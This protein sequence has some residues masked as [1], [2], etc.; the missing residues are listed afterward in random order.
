[1][2]SSTKFFELQELLDFLVSKKFQLPPTNAVLIRP[3]PRP[4]YYILHDDIILIN[5]LG[6]GAFGEVWK[7]VWRK[8][9][10]TS[11]DVAVKRMKGNS[12]KSVIKEF[13]KEAK[14]MRK[15]KHPNIV[16]IIGVAPSEEPLMIC[17][18]L[19]SNGCLKNYLKMKKCTLDQLTNFCIDAARGMSYLSSQMIIHRDLAARNLLLGS[20]IEVKIADFGLSEAGKTEVKINKMKLP[21]RWLA[22]ETIDTGWFTTKTDVWSYA[23][24]IWE[25]FSYCANDPFPGLTNNQA[26]DLIRTK[27]PPMQAPND[28]PSII[29]RLMLDCFEKKPENRPTFPQL[30]KKLSPKEDVEQYNKQIR[31]H[32]GNGLSASTCSN[33]QSEKGV[34]VNGSDLKIKASKDGNISSDR[35]VRIIIPAGNMTLPQDSK[36]S[37]TKM[38]TSKPAK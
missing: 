24:T 2:D 9:D 36:R 34:S 37:K 1:M 3:I 25:I 29:V 14:L 8:R 35:A 27:T 6:S 32:D 7:G 18:E 10:K 26:K 11:V 17:I 30:L 28:T 20:H 38:V 21:I 16:T 31:I 23:V 13:V 22:P 12:T 5:K 33:S 15:L 4:E 19:A